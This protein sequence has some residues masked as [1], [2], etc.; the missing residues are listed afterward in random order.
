MRIKESVCVHVKESVFAGECVSLSAC[1]CKGMYACVRGCVPVKKI[2]CACV[3]KF[4]MR[5]KETVCV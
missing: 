4:F 3:G 1:T 5:V 2:V